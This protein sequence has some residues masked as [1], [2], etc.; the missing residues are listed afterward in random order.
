MKQYVWIFIAVGAVILG[1]LAWEGFRSALFAKEEVETVSTHNL[2]LE[3]IESLGKLELV[4][5]K[6]KDVMEYE[7]KYQYL[8][9][10][11]VVLVVS[12]EAVGCIDLQKV[13]SQDI[14]ETDSILHVKLPEPEVC[15][16]KVNHKDSKVYDTDWTY[17]DDAELIDE[18]Y[19]QAEAKVKEVALESNILEQTR[20]NAEKV[21]K[22]LLQQISGKRVLLSYSKDGVSTGRDK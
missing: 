12:G 14:T 11:K 6:F 19:E 22:P 5:Y 20:E 16:Y 9:N 3:E 10:S 1:A 15:Y 18:A 4:K 21:L 17:F 7:V 2:V 13:R 8:P